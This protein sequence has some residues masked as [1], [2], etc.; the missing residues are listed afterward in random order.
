MNISTGNKSLLPASLLGLMELGP[1]VTPEVVATAGEEDL[2]QKRNVWDQIDQRPLHPT[3]MGNK[4]S[5][6]NHRL[7][8][9]SDEINSISDSYLPNLVTQMGATQPI[10]HQ[11][12]LSKMGKRSDEITTI[13]DST[14]VTTKPHLQTLKITDYDTTESPIVYQKIDGDHKGDFRVV[15]RGEH[16]IQ[17]EI[18][19]SNHK[20][21]VCHDSCGFEAGSNEELSIVQS[22]IEKKAG[23]RR[24]EDRLH[25]IW[26]AKYSRL[27]LPIVIFERYCVPMDNQRP[28][29]DLKFFD[30][31]CPDKNVPVIAVFTKYDQFLRNV[32]MYLED[33]GNPDDNISDTAERRFKEHYL[34][35]LGDGTRFV[36]LEKM[37][38]P[39]TRCHALLVETAEALNE[40]VVALMLLAVQTKDLELRINLAFK[41]KCTIGTVVYQ[42]N[43]WLGRKIKW[44]V[45]IPASCLSH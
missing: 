5:K 7:N 41:R 20:G 22:F 14:V 28:E 9:R 43:H 31:I 19:F 37:Q 6:P 25:A 10:R 34:R 35:H 21:Y 18:E 17:D 42:A 39:E 40:D 45:V 8:V 13:G 1:E 16:R 15:R 30:D 29:L 27:R 44:V 26:F 36:R 23:Q 11:H 24:L 38:K 4:H 32:K 2:D 33:Y 12:S 3:N